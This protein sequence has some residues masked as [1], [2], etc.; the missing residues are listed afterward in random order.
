MVC[1]QFEAHLNG[2]N[3]GKGNVEIAQIKHIGGGHVVVLRIKA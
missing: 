2:E 1:G 3:D